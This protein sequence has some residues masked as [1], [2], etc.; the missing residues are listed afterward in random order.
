MVSALQVEVGLP[1][2]AICFQTE[3]RDAR[4]PL[5]PA[6]WRADAGVCAPKTKPRDSF[7]ATESCEDREA[8]G[9]HGPV[10]SKTA[11][12]KVRSLTGRQPLRYQD[13]CYKWK[14]GVPLEG[15]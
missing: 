1:R 14:R 6:L 10:A 7:R 11:I 9:V 4:L 3:T 12:L 13:L 2:R 15:C 8:A 5:S